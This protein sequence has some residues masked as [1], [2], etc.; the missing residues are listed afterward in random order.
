MA[1]CRFVMWLQHN[2]IVLVFVVFVLILVTTYWPGRKSQH[3][4]ARPHPARR[5]PLRS[6][7]VPTKIEKDAVTGHDD[8]RPRVGRAK[9][10]NTPLPKWWLY[11]LYATYRL[12]RG[13]VRAVSVGALGSPAISTACWA[14]RS[15]TRWTPMCAR[16]RRSAPA[17]WTRS[18]RCRSPR[19]A[20]IRSCWRRPRRRAASPSPTTASPAMAPAAAG[21]PGYPGAGGR[22]LDL[23][24]H[25]RGDP[26]DRHLR[27][28]QRRSRCARTARCRASAPTAC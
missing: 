4:A 8:H 9:E 25:A 16:W 12:G 7:A 10:L 13:L 1:L 26:A 15:A 20:R 28:P 24:R 6:D 19:S 11:V 21:R 27:H 22:C 5:R 14:I 23:G 3:R 18:R 2:S 17:R